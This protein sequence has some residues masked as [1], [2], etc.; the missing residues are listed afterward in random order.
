MRLLLNA[1]FS[2]KDTW[3]PAQLYGMPA[4][5][6][7]DLLQMEKTTETWCLTKEMRSTS[8]DMNIH[9]QVKVCLSHCRLG[10]IPSKKTPNKQTQEQY[11]PPEHWLSFSLEFNTLRRAFI[12][13]F[14]S[15][16]RILLT[17]LFL[18]LQKRLCSILYDGVPSNVMLL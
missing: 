4:P 12:T 5:E 8:V 1:C 10:K 11:F 14:L 9:L 13:P 16:W 2:I 3:Q 6:C 17:L 18:F 15:H 7:K